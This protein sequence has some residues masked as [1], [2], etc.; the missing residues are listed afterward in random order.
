[1]QVAGSSAL[2]S[3]WD[4]E[5]F[6]AGHVAAFEWLGGV[7]E[8]CVF[9]NPKTAVKKILTGP[10]REEHELFSSLKAYYLLDADFCNPRCCLP[11]TLTFSCSTVSPRGSKRVREASCRYC[12]AV[13]RRRGGQQLGLAI[14]RT[15]VHTLAP[16]LVDLPQQ[17][18]DSLR[19]ARIIPG[20]APA[21]SKSARLE[22]QP[23]PLALASKARKGW[24]RS[25]MPKR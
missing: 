25:S 5:A 13:N 9:D 19:E 3:T 11:T 21:R 2:H 1:M 16:S 17:P 20:A 12:G 22:T 18:H 7:P 15:L 23:N 4:L 8:H 14:T 10:W 6:L 24:F